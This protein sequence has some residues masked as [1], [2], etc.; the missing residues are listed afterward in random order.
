MR[1]RHLTMPEYRGGTGSHVWCAWCRARLNARTGVYLGSDDLPYCES[2]AQ[3]QVIRRRPYY[4]R[5]GDVAF[6]KNCSVWE[7]IS[8]GK[9]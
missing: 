5:P 2:C 3:G 7:E 9:Q 4:R 6:R 8:D 1:Y